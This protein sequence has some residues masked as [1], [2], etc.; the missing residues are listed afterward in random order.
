MVAHIYIGTDSR[1]P[2]PKARR[3]GYVLECEGHP[4]TRE[5]FGELTGTYNQAVI[6]AAAAALKRFNRRCEIR[7]HT[8]NSYVLEMIAR[9]L[10]TWA[11]N[12]FRT[13]AGKPL[14]HREDWERLWES[15]QDQIICGIPGKH[16]YSEW[17]ENELKTRENQ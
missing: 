5:G 2:R 9:N 11:K 4:D 6:Q 12:E 3:Y 10:G 15:I 16:A 14:K 8:E 13:A 7:I 1:S 17:I